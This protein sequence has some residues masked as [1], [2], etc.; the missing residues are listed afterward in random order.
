MLV[1]TTYTLIKSLPCLVQDEL[2]VNYCCSCW[3][4][5]RKKKYFNFLKLIRTF[6]GD[7][8]KSVESR[9]RGGLRLGIKDQK[10]CS[11]GDKQSQ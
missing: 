9:S 3:T 11:Q 4:E 6:E 1:N 10:S 8:V 2:V 5:K 7:E